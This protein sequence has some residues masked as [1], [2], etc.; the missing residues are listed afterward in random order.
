MFIFR[1]NIRNNGKKR[2]RKNIITLIKSWTGVHPSIR[3]SF[4]QLTAMVNHTSVGEN[5]DKV[6]PQKPVFITSR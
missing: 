5:A 1:F 2:C 3:V 4:S 6:N